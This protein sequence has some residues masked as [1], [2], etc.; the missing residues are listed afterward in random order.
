MTAA[1]FSLQTTTTNERGPATVT[2]TGELDATNAARFTAAV[3]QIA[4]GRAVVLDLSDLL[5]VDSAGFAAL[6]RILANHAVTIALSPLSPLRKAA[7][8]MDLPHQDTVEQAVAALRFAV[9][10]GAGSGRNEG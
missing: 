6:H 2:V 3:E 10:G 5:Y 1:N 4:T 9:R 7:A 8:L